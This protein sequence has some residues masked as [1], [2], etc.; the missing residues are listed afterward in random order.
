M[1]KSS[2]QFQKVAVH[3]LIKKG[4]KFLVTL[5]SPVN[6]YKPNEWDLAGGTVEFGEEPENALKREI[7]EETR[8]KVSINKPIYMCT[9]T[10]NLR[11]Q[12]WLVYECTYLSGEV[13]L[14]PE[15]HSD[16]KWVTKKELKELKKIF[17]VESFYKNYLLK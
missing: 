10:Q 7:K 9:Q 4:N 11:H 14:N 3:G 15:E 13:K 16:Y 2:K 5:R 6:D 12:F 8:L 1:L 17:F